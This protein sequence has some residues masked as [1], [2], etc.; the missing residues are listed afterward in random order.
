M[1]LLVLLLVQRWLQSATNSCS[2]TSCWPVCFL[3][4]P[5]VPTSAHV[6][7]C[8]CHQLAV[9][10][11]AVCHAHARAGSRRGDCD[12]NKT[13]ELVALY[14][15]KPRSVLCTTFGT[16]RVF[17][18][19]LQCMGLRDR[20]RPLQQRWDGQHAEVHGEHQYATVAVTRHCYITC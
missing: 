1:L 14:N 15:I 11:V 2:A 18:V 10:V 3:A 6:H 7:V 4:V 12:A 20:P 8:R 19:L 5:T 13:K 9:Q 17:S 16:I